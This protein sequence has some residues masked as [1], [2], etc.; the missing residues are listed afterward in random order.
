MSLAIATSAEAGRLYVAAA[1]IAEG[2]E[3]LRAR[4][5]A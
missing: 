2:E 1:A 5:C 3:V 4:P